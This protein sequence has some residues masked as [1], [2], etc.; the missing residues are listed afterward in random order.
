VQKKLH[1]IIVFLAIIA[2]TAYGVQAWYNQQENAA[3]VA[4]SA[5]NYNDETPV[6]IEDEAEPS[7]FDSV[8]KDEVNEDEKEPEIE[9]IKTENKMVVELPEAPKREAPQSDK[10]KQEPVV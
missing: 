1:I 6:E 8:S 7:L 4:F 9:E 10:D 5:G 2:M 3:I